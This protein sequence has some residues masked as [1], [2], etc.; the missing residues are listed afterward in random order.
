VPVAFT[1]YIRMNATM[2]V[3]PVMAPLPMACAVS[4]PMPPP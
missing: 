3:A 1:A 4:C 2:S